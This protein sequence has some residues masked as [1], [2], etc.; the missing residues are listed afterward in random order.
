MAT[1][2]RTFCCG[3]GNSGC[4][5]EESTSFTL[6]WNAITGHLFYVHRCAQTERDETA[7]GVAIKQLDDHFTPQVNSAFERH[8]FRAMKQLS[9]ETIDQ[10]ITRLR[11]KAD[12]CEFGDRLAENIRDQ[13]IE[14]CISY[15]LQE[16]C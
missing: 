2:I 16:N 3:E 11:Q 10:F 9:D 14:R 4:T 15:H 12:F 7:Y 13:V 5:T 1:R 6:W 8:L